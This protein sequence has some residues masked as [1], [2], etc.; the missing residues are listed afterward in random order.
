[1]TK[2]IKKWSL[3]ITGLSV[4]LG[5]ILF[6]SSC[7]SGVSS[8]IT[9]QQVNTGNGNIFYSSGSNNK[10]LADIS[11]QSLSTVGGMNTWINSLANEFIY[12][13]FKNINSTASNIEEKWEDWTT[14]TDELWD[15]KLEEYNVKNGSDA[16]YFIQNELLSPFGG[17]VEDWK[18]SQ[19]I[20]LANNEF[21][22]LIEKDYIYLSTASN[23]KNPTELE[24]NNVNNINGKTAVGTSNNFVFGTEG[25]SGNEAGDIER[26]IA[27]F[28]EFIFDEYVRNE[29]PYLTSMS[30]YKH[31]APMNSSSESKWFDVNKIQDF[32]KEQ[33]NPIPVEPNY[34][35]QVYEEPSISTVNGVN[36]SQKYLNLVPQL[37]EGKFLNNSAGGSIDIPYNNGEYTDDTATSFLVTK[38]TSFD[39]LFLPFASAGS[40]KMNN[41]LYNV[42]DP[43][44]TTQEAISTVSIMDN[45]LT[46]T[47]RTGAFAL[48]T[49]IASSLTGK[50][51]G[52]THISDTVDL[53]ADSPFI[54]S[55]NEAGVHIMGIDRYQAM[56]MAS[57]DPTVG[58]DGVIE[59]M[60]NTLKWRHVQTREGFNKSGLTSESFNLNNLINSYF[61]TNRSSLL[62]KYIIERGANLP[63]EFPTTGNVFLFSEQ[64]SKIDRDGNSETFELLLPNESPLAI[65]ILAA[66]EEET[67]RNVNDNIKSK[68][69][70]VQDS[71]TNKYSL[72][73]FFNENDSTISNGIAG[74]LPYTRN[75]TNGNYDSIGYFNKLT[76]NVWSFDDHKYSALVSA[77]NPLVNTYVDGLNL[78]KQKLDPFYGVYNQNILT[79]NSLINESIKSVISSDISDD[80]I[81]SKIE[82]EIAPIYNAKTNK[83]VID[84]VGG[85]LATTRPTA[86]ATPSETT[87]YINNQIA[88]IFQKQYILKKY[89]TDNSNLYSDGNWNNYSQL[90]TIAVND[91]DKNITKNQAGEI[92][93]NSSERKSL[94]QFILTIQYAL[95]WNAESKTYT[96]EPYKNYLSNNTLNNAKAS[97]IWLDSDYADIVK[98]YGTNLDNDFGFVQNPIALT[99][100]SNTYGYQ[101]Q[102]PPTVTNNQ[103]DGA[104]TT[105]T[106]DS[107][108]FN[109]IKTTNN[110]TTDYTGFY[111]LQF[112]SN[113]D[114]PSYVS[115]AVFDNSLVTNDG[116]SIVKNSGTLYNY[117]NRTN[118]VN[119][120]ETINNFSSLEVFINE[121]VVNFN[122]DTKPIFDAK[123]LEE[124][125]AQLIIQVKDVNII[126]DVAFE[127]VL[128][129]QI[130][131]PE[132]TSSN[133]KFFGSPTDQNTQIVLTQ[134]NN[135]DVNKAFG[136]NGI[137]WAIPNLLN[138]SDEAFFWGLVDF[139]NNNTS[140][141]GE[142]FNNMVVNQ[143]KVI[144]YDVRLNNALGSGLVEDFKRPR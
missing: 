25:L 59:E 129:K 118:V 139:A 9:D 107:N 42:T 96:F 26:G 69:Y 57:A 79:N 130:L 20:T 1:M 126:P 48:P 70:A 123:T 86:N 105:L 98:N 138:S 93:I 115:K 104:N 11:K 78:E 119:T 24:I 92:I 66:K 22:S 68:L 140:L 67:W 18:K 4:A 102:T 113:N 71:Y 142:A 76:D 143:G 62:V 43:N 74:I 12:S 16:P 51:T 10:N 103:F 36:A 122:I 39:N 29:M 121:L 127:V 110:A 41:V 125:K 82:E 14:S 38:K 3:G 33:I 81:I 28:K 109:A 73:N 31:Q 116:T 120:I 72:P 50:Y 117:E 34:A 54:L 61:S 88:N 21:T 137:N 58:F 53:G 60:K 7:G 40:Y 114:L 106:N 8:A 112:E 2:K 89:I 5:S 55:R 46:N 101:G 84:N 135:A 134:F 37:V 132:A 27:D 63:P 19:M 141:Q 133:N 95:G 111:G 30:L 83:F 77:V 56:K 15:A 35:W 99:K 90:L 6:L 144:V 87:N 80:I 45:F 136:E 108:Y 75:I 49:E 100:Y 13:W 52:M 32:N 128:N 64:I 124:Q 47:A 85:G 65:A 44:V 91:H 17:N 131:N 97:Y 23:K 94:Y